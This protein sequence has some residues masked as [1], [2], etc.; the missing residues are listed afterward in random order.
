MLFSY[1]VAFR[2]FFQAS[3][4]DAWRK[5][6]WSTSTLA[7][8]R[9]YKNWFGSS[10]LRGASWRV[11][12]IK[13]GTRPH[14]EATTWVHKSSYFQNHLAHVS[15]FQQENP[16]SAPTVSFLN[17]MAR[18]NSVIAQRFWVNVSVFIG[19]IR[20]PWCTSCPA[21]TPGRKNALTGRFCRQFL[22]MNS[23]APGVAKVDENS[24]RFE[25]H[26]YCAIHTMLPNTF[27][28]WI[29]PTF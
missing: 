12:F 13:T 18:L 6:P 17:G 8:G 27:Q 16:T 28:Q 19:W 21:C 14:F 25:C 23:L 10:C 1:C 5:I 15:T 24:R 11:W 7:L 3:E 29:F 9:K 20:S 26:S 2:L 22:R 4:H